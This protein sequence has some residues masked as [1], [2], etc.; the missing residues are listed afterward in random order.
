MLY[1]TKA[2]EHEEIELAKRAQDL[3]LDV[4]IQ[5]ADE[6]QALESDVKFDVLGGI[7][8]KCD[9]KLNPMKLMKQLIAYLKG[10]GVLFQDQTAVKG[11]NISG[12]K[13]KELVTDKGNFKGDEFVLCPGAY[14][15]EL[16][17]KLNLKLPLMPGK[18][19]SFMYTAPTGVKLA[20]AAL[21][22]EARVAVTPMNG[23]IRFGGTME[24][25]SPN[26]KIY[27]NRVE[28]IVNSIPKYLTNLDVEY[29]KEDIWYGYRPCTPDGLPYL[30][31]V[32]KYEN[33]AIAAGAGMMGLSLG[34]AM[35]KAISDIL[36]NKKFETNIS[37]F[38]PD[39]FG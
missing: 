24:L 36:S 35:G 27:Q 4:E 6:M 17:N 37:T 23:K 9:G 2:L 1:K 3:G 18:G 11:F 14:L 30:G 32:T 29:P 31:R 28:G 38:S 15:M 25:G 39:R 20:H 5:S 7:L 8:Y 16:T 33:V 34:P 22:L 10:K 19:Y 21:L 13:I 26:N 12:K